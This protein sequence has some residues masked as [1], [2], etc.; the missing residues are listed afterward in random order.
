MLWLLLDQEQSSGQSL[1]NRILIVDDEP[2][3]TFS[4]KMGLERLGFQVD[5]YNNPILAA[6]NY[7]PNLYDLLLIDIRMPM[8]N[9]FELYKEIRK[10]DKKVKVCFITAYDINNEDFKKSFPTMTLRHFIKK[11][12]NTPVLAKELRKILNEDFEIIS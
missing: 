7:Q 4:F 3:I 12:I 9:G 5:T 10:I 8:M 11:P 1:N 6:S 2:D